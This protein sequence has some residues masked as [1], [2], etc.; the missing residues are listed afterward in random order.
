MSDKSMLMDTM[1]ELWRSQIKKSINNALEL[2]PDD[3]LDWAPENGMIPLGMLFLHISETSDWWYEEVMM[4]H[5]STELAFFDKTCPEKDVIR[6][7]LQ[8]HWDRMERFFLEPTRTFTKV[9]RFEGSGRSFESSGYD[10]FI[11]IFEHD[12]HHRSQ[13]NQY[14]R[15]LGIEPPRI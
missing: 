13:I 4:G 7:H 9:Y 10:I 15:I 11:H 3:K 5:S 12:I 8:V 1:I 6:K 2:T 14:L